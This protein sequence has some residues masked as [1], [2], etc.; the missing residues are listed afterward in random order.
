MS[1]IFICVEII[2]VLEQLQWKLLKLPELNLSNLIYSLL[3]LLLLPLNW[4]LEAWKWKISLSGILHLPYLKAFRSVIAGT[5]TGVITPNRVGEFA[6]RILLL[7][8]NVRKQA[9]G[10]NFVCSFSQLWA[11]VFFGTVAVGKYSDM[12]NPGA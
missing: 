11:T 7:P 2:H 4:G 8:E 10:L 9:V 3:I 5:A 12:L 6:G 1:L